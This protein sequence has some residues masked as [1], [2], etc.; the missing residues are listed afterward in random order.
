MAVILGIVTFIAAFFF[1]P[2]FFRSW[3][4]LL[5]LFLLSSGI[6]T[7]L[8]YEFLNIDTLNSGAIGPTGP[9]VVISCTL[10]TFTGTITKSLY[11]I[12]K[13]DF[14]QYREQ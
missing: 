14:E 4:I 13:S 10:A 5:G 8:I 9:Y 2:L 6:L 1:I 12:I 11:L 3:L 7:F